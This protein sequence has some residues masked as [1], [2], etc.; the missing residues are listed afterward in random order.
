MLNSTCK[1]KKKKQKKMLTK[2]EKHFTIFDIDFVSIRK[3][4]V[5]LTF[6]KPSYIGLCI[7]ELSKVLMYEFHYDYIKINMVTTQGYYSKTLIV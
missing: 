7:L 3:N 5:T 4:K 2:I 6:N 1:K